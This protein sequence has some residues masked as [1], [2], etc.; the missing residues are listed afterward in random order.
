MNSLVARPGAR[1][2]LAWCAVIAAGSLFANVC[3][4]ACPSPKTLGVLSPK[5]LAKVVATA[6][7]APMWIAIIIHHLRMASGRGNIKDAWREAAPVLLPS[8][9]AF[10]AC[11]MWLRYLH[12]VIPYDPSG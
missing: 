6:G 1:L 7:P 5:A 8:L 3:G 4:T 11:V 12:Y 9:A 2:M 10:L